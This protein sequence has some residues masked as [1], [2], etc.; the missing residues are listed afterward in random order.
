MYPRYAGKTRTQLAEII[1]PKIRLI[2]FCPFA[3]LLLQLELFGYIGDRWSQHKTG[4][5]SLY[6]T[7][8]DDAADYVALLDKCGEDSPMQK[9]IISIVPI[10][11]LSDISLRGFPVAATASKSNAPYFVR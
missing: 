10:F 6:G 3:F 8:L 5:P 11:M 4:M 1:K 2:W 9:R 7:T